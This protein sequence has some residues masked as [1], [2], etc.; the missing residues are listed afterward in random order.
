MFDEGDVNHARPMDF[1]FF[2]PLS[3]TR[4]SHHWLR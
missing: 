1:H 3:G 2:I 4:C